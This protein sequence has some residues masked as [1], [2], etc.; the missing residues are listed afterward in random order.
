MLRFDGDLTS[1]GL[2]LDERRHPLVEAATPREEWAAWLQRYPSMAAMFDE[3]ELA[4]SPGRWIRTSRLQR[5]WA[6]AAGAD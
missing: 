5:R 3:A 6:Q 4:A 2:V 1:V